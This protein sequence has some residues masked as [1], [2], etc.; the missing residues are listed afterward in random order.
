MKRLFTSILLAIKRAKVQIILVFFIYCISCSAGILMSHLGNQFSLNTRDKI[1]KK[2][3][4][5]DKASINYQKG[6]NLSAALFDFSGNLF[7]GAVP[8]TAMGLSIVIPFITVSIQG[9]IGGIVSVDNNHLSRFNN[10]KSTLYYIIVI[11]L[12]FI[13]YSIAIGSGIKFGLDCYTYNKSLNFK[14]FNYKFKK[15][16]LIDLGYV[17]IAVIPLFFIASLFEFLSSWNV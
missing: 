5:S 3:Y 12:Q 14:L 4:H 7:F 15:E 1:V 2:A 6:K 16:S 11:L 13:P 8:Q 10:I 9:W 17:F